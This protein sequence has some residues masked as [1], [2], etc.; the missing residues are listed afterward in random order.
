MRVKIFFLILFIFISGCT[1]IP[2]DEET[3]TLKSVEVRNYEG[4]R[5]DSFDSFRENSIAGPQDINLTRYNLEI[6]GL[7]NNPRNLSYEEVLAYPSYKK[8]VTLYCVEGWDSRVLWEGVLIEDLIK[9]AKPEANTVIFHAYDGY[10]SSLSR[11]FIEDNKILLAYNIN[12][13]TLPS[14][15]GF[16]FQV[17]AEDKWGYK[18][19]RWVTK[20]ELSDDPEYRGF[21]EQRGYNNNGSLDLPK[22]D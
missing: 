6:Y 22:F 8:I 20:I 15:N 16:P 12:N 1:Q 9:D 13:M 7:T 5:L 11:R 18:W 2:A 4:K 21:W 3:I 14:A 10:T 19:T 17:V